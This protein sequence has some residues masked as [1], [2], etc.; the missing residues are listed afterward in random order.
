MPEP[1][2]A[3]EVAQWLCELADPSADDPLLAE[4]QAL[5]RERGFPIVGPEVG[6]LLAQVTRMLGARRIFEM[7]SGFGYSTLWF[8][9]AAG[10]GANVFHTDGDPDNTAQAKEFLARAGVVDRV[11]FLCGDAMALLRQTEGEFDIVFCDVDKQQYPEAYEAFR[12]RVRV[13]GAVIIDN[14]VW[15]GRVARGDDSESTVGVRGYIA[16]MWNNPA[17]LS[18]LMPVRD[19]VG[20]SLRLR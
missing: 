20:L 16:R 17:F 6:R 18:S 19:G 13:G 5:A 4:M 3:T 2:I 9:R 1:V 8:A 12:E 10:D 11:T 15:S 14:L 7:G